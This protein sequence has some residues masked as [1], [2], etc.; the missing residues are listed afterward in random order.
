MHIECFAYTNASVLKLTMKLSFQR[1]T[2]TPNFLALEAC[3]S[4]IAFF[5]MKSIL[6]GAVC[7][8]GL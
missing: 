2:E 3:T 8:S 5:K 6:L 4:E 1:I 7:H